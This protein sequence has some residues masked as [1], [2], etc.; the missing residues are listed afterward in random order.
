MKTNSSNPNED[1]QAI[2][3]IMERSSKF[4][5]LSGLAGIFAG[6]CALVGAAVAW[7]FIFDSGQI[8]YSGHLQNYISS[9]N[10]GIGFYLALDALLVLVF[11]VLG[12]VYFSF[13]KAKKAGRQ[14]WTNSTRRL[15]F[16]LMLPLVSGGFIILILIFRNKPDMVI[17]FMLVFYGLALVNAGKFTF[18][19]IHYLGLTQIV[20]GILAAVFINYGLLLWAIGF[21]LMHIVY[22]TMMFYRHERKK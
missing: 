13:R 5:S 6:V 18:S 7:F 21:G 2:R 11:A 17:S 15:L 1:I 12:A 19:E 4:L 3:E 8:R 22:G 9:I 16:H 20:L 14:F 10:S